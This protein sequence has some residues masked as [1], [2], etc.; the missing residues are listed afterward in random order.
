VIRSSVAL[1]AILGQG[2]TVARLAEM[3]GATKFRWVMADTNE[4]VHGSAV[5][6]I[7]WKGVAQ[8]VATDICGDP[9][10]LGAA[11]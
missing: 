4:P 2:R 8:I 7:V 9:I 11:A 10:Q 6:R 1:E 3:D 5:N